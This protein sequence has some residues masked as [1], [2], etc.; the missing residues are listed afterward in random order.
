MTTLFLYL[1]LGL[2][3]CGGGDDEEPGGAP[4]EDP[5]HPLP[6][7]KLGPTAPR[8]RPS[9]RGG[10]R[11]QGPES[12]L[13][14][15]M[16]DDLPDGGPVSGP[17]CIT[18]DIQCGQTVVGHTTGGVDRFDTKFYEKKFCTPALTD[19]DGG[20]ER[21]YRLQIPAGDWTAEV[22]LDTP[23]ADLDLAAM[24]FDGGEDCPTLKDDVPRCEMWPK[25]RGKREHVRLV[26]QRPTTWFIV[27]EGKKE[28]EGPFALHVECENHL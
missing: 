17:G 25:P 18:A 6:E 9:P 27:V 20:D 15:D 26:S 19:H 4:P 14:K 3:G 22:Y 7:L 11:Q 10:G 12:A 1:T 21:V 28:E 24:V 5:E 2:L 13:D 16:C 8:S 23:C